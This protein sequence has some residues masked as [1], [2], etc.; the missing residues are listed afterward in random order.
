ME[1][2]RLSKELLAAKK[3]NA[4]ETFL[5]SVLR[6]EGNSWSEIYNYV[7]RRK[8]NWE[9]APAIKDHN[10]TII[11]DTTEKANIL[12]SYYASVFCCDRKISEIKL[13]TSVGTFIIFTKV[14]RKRFAK[15]W[16]KNSRARWSS[17]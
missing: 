5:R 17:W 16:R 8:E 15:I 4:H 11:T 6:N 3:K 1:L 13:V 9:T 7:K 10:G 2:T 14:I 12:N